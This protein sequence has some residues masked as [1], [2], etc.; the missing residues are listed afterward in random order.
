[1][2]ANHEATS[3]AD[4][5]DAE[6]LA[7][8]NGEETAATMDAEVRKLAALAG[9]SLHNDDDVPYYTLSAALNYVARG[10]EVFPTR[11]G[12][13]KS[14]KSKEHSNGQNWGKTTDPEVV[15][16]DWKRWPHAGVSVA[17][18]RTSGI[19][20]IDVDNESHG[21]D[22]YASLR[23]LEEKH[24]RLPTTLTV[25]T[26]SGGMHLYFKYPNDFEVKNG[27]SKIADGIDF[28][29]EG[30]KVPAPP[31][32]RPGVGVY[33]WTNDAPIA[34]APRWLLD[35]VAEKPHAQPKA[36]GKAN[37]HGTGPTAY[38]RKALESECDAVRK[39]TTKG[40]RNS[41]LNDAAH[42]L[43]QLVAGGELD[44]GEVRTRLY[45]A[46]VASGY[47]RDDGEARARATIESGLKA[48]MKKPRG[49]PERKEA[50]ARTMAEEPGA[51]DAPTG[52]RINFVRASDVEQKPVVWVWERRLAR[53]KLT[54]F[55]GEPRVGKSQV[56]C[57]II[58]RITCGG[59]F[60]DGQIAPKGKCII[61][62]AEDDAADTICPRLE[63]A[64]ANLDNVCILESVRDPQ[65]KRQT[66][67]LGRDLAVLQEKVE[68]MGDVVL[69]VVD[70][71]TAYLGATLDSHRATSVRAVLEPLKDF[72]EK[73]KCAIL[74]VTHPPK[75]NQ[76]KAMNS[77]IGSQA[78][79]AAA[80]VALLACEEPDSETDRRLFLG[81]NATNSR[82]AD[83]IGYNL[84]EG[85]TKK[86][87]KTCHVVWDNLPVDINANEA[88]RCLSETERG[89]TQREA[90]EFLHHTLSDGPKGSD[91]VNAAAKDAGISVRTLK[92]AKK[93]LGVVSE[94]EKGVFDSGKWVM[95][96]P[97]EQGRRRQHR[98][99]EQSKES[100]VERM[101]KRMHA[102]ECMGHIPTPQEVRALERE[103]AR[104]AGRG[105]RALP[106]E[107]DDGTDNKKFQ[108][109]T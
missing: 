28:K 42:A 92:R 39:A 49:T 50:N 105:E 38:S 7:F 19:L 16:R 55:S 99:K 75:S 24:G 109:V 107:E 108:G 77:F 103:K 46:A 60:P 82:P 98:T 3:T 44:V 83:G 64:G 30:G 13:Q 59:M 68:E 91:E 29:G 93:K 97:E 34:D 94:K 1:M 53:G 48:G 76:S 104:E 23:A 56:A 41:I 73:S 67:N 61:L 9:A 78:F 85:V 2:Y 54:L 86:G 21:V 57:D 43:G 11:P 6:E 26:P 58:A 18:G 27:T 45:E 72:T 25:E 106:V 74:G 10:W 95:R 79:G 12:E 35:L 15:K 101:E 32:T 47:V 17:T 90:E 70:P 80:R 20:V 33:Q 89:S 31:T 14:Y 22:G 96:L 62:S 40:K 88:V 102:R 36:N 69:I 66:L 4:D 65:D 81:V 37:G 84:V 5:I 51:P 63:L 52:W 100:T 87:I 71:L 8:L